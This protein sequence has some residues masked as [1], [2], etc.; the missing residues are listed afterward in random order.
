M[1]G[2][3]DLL[4]LNPDNPLGR[5]SRES[6]N[7]ARTNIPRSEQNQKFVPLRADY[8]TIWIPAFAGMTQLFV[9]MDYLG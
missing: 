5:H 1:C 3:F 2:Y 8:S 7:P 4:E 6:G 9:L